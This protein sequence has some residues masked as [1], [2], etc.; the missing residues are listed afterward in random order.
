M[1]TLLIKFNNKYYSFKF[2]DTTFFT[3]SLND[4]CA[5]MTQDKPIG[6]VSCNLG[7]QYQY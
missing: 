5:N 7:C 4:S 1:Q 6:S 3:I 2:S